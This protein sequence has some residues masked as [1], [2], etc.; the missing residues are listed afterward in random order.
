ME[1]RNI[2][3]LGATGSIGKSALEV[4]ARHE[5]RFHVTALAAYRN[6]EML[7]KQFHRFHPRFLCLIDPD[8]AEQLRRM[9]D[10]ED[11]TILSGVDEMLSLTRLDD[12]SMVLNAI[13][14]AAGLRAS[15]ATLKNDKDL[16]LANK[17]SLVAGGPLFKSLLARSEGKLLPID[18]EHS[19]IWQATRCGHPR[20]VRKILL[21]SSGGPFRTWPKEK[22]SEITVEAAL[23]HPTWKMGP[24]ITID[25]ATLANKGLEVIE[26]VYL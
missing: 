26:A 24:K 13:V 12:V 3:I 8:A 19:A 2:V 23:N 16:A 17:E 5:D 21:T 4:I 14:G 9:L 1:R 15:L 18:S 10:G 22:F 20:E 11:V 6:A 25:S 7:A